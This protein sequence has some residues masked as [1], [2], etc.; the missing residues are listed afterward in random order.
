MKKVFFLFKFYLFSLQVIFQTCK[1]KADVQL[2]G[3]TEHYFLLNSPSLDQ[4][5]HTV[6][7][8]TRFLFFIIYMVHVLI[9]SLQVLCMITSCPLKLADARYLYDRK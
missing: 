3:I 2:Q 8:S 6:V 7:N 4:V 1:L 9:I 5:I